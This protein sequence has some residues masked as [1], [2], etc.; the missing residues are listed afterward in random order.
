MTYTLFEWA[1]DN[2]EELTKSQPDKV[3]LPENASPTEMKALPDEMVFFQNVN[4]LENFIKN[5]KY[6]PFKITSQC[7]N[8][9]SG[10]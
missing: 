5:I 9:L 4:I 1:K 7:C 6:F 10:L 2:A 3:A 8:V